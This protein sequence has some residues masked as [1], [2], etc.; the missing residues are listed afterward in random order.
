MP[1][2]VCYR[3]GYYTHIGEAER[4]LRLKHTT[5]LDSDQFDE[6]VARVEELLTE[7]WNKPKGRKK[8]LSLR[9]AVAVTVGYSRQN[10]IQEVLGERWNV[11]QET[12]SATISYLTPLIEEATREFVPTQDEAA[13]AVAGRVC[14]LDGSLGPCWSWSGHDELWTRKHGTT[15]HNFQVI[16]GLTGNVFFIS[17]PVPGSVHDSV[18]ITM[19]P[20]ASILDHSGGTIADKGY[21]GCGY[22]TPRK[23]P[24]RG[25]LSVGDKRENK[26][27][28]RLR[29]PVE[30]AM[31]QIKSWRIL[32]T[33]YRRP[34]RAYP[35]SFRATI[36]L[37]FFQAS[38]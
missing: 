7:P 16:T 10:T 22:A 33:D 38:F 17:D 14:L 27:L 21:Q 8:K 12:V 34:L 35:T 18:A 6:L 30:R 3:C 37:F 2:R 13:E 9:D 19:T 31:A 1:S 5:G 36:G 26:N 28:S 4:A 23:K 15:G 20:I 11:S 24:Q 25:E 32:H 29:A